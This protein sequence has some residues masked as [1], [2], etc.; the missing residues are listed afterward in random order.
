MTHIDQITARLRELAQEL[1][2]PDLDDARA[3]ELA[4]EASELIAEAE[5][6]IDSRLAEAARA[7]A[8]EAEA[9]EPS[10]GDG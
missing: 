2:N 10:A 8:G 1:G 4:R 7:G 3:G 9:D 5:T 6:E